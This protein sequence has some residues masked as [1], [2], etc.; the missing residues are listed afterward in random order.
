MGYNYDDHAG[1][2]PFV[3]RMEIL[4]ALAHIRATNTDNFKDVA[5]FTGASV[6]LCAYWVTHSVIP[7]L[8]HHRKTIIEFSR[9]ITNAV[10]MHHQSSQH[11]QASAPG[12]GT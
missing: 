6:R 1:R 3:E 4:N 10:Q 12:Q 11:S 8:P 5:K 2:V 7:T 9:S